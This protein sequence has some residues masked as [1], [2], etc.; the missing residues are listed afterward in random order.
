VPDAVLGEL[1][2]KVVAAIAE[3][4]DRARRD[5]AD[6]RGWKP[7]WLP[8]LTQRFTANLIHERIWA[9]LLT[10]LAPLEGDGVTLIDQE[11][12]REVCVMLEGGRTYR[13]RFKRHSDRNLI[14]SYPTPTDIAFWGAPAAA[15]TL[16]G[17]EEIRLAAGYRWNEETR[18]MGA[19]VISYRE[20]KGNPIWAV[21][22]EAGAAAQPISWAPIGGPSLPTIDLERSLDVIDDS[23]DAAGS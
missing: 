8:T 17:M 9:H 18:D 19:T 22:I 3:S 5:L 11:P 2:D 6:F 7:E 13:L 20:G 23:E 14:R 12:T 16:D 1:G 15:P 21:E 4:T 10:E